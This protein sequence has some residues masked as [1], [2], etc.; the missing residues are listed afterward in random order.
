MELLYCRIWT[1]PERPS[2]AFA[3]EERGAVK[4]NEKDEK[5][6]AEEEKDKNENKKDDG[7][8]DSRF[9]SDRGRWR[10]TRAAWATEA[11]PPS[12]GARSA[13]SRETATPGWTCGT[14]VA[15]SAG[16]SIEAPALF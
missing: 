7:I 2:D 9:S 15:A 12:R 5:K 6:N 13:D 10:M 1:G 11:R 3:A 8:G 14:T 4:N 16:A